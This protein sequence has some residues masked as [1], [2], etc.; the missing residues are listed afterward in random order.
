MRQTK[1]SR[2]RLDAPGAWPELYMSQKA[3]ASTTQMMP[4]LELPAACCKS[5][6][7]QEALSLK[8]DEKET[9]VCPREPMRRCHEENSLHDGLASSAHGLRQPDGVAGSSKLRSPLC[10][11][12]CSLLLRSAQIPSEEQKPPRISQTEDPSPRAS[13]S[14]AMLS[15]SATPEHSTT[16][17]SQNSKSC[18]K[19]GSSRS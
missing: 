16:S 2:M 12:G 6:G 4:A 10:R 17:L 11:N 13:S 5:S 18:T 14:E 7:P 8:G 15:G 1:A 19:L 3:E 9:R